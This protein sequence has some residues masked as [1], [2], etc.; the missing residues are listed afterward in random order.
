MAETADTDLRDQPTLARRIAAVLI[1]TYALVLL[2]FALPEIPLDGS[3]A[4]VIVR[5]ADSA[6][7]GQLPFLCIA[8]L[9]LLNSRPGPSMRRRAIEAVTIIVVMLGVIGG[10][11]LLNEFVIKPTFHVPRPNIVALAEDGALG[12]AVPD[13]PAFYELGDKQDR[14]DY[15]S[16]RLA[17]L[18][19][20]ALAPAVREHW[21]D[22]TGYSFPS[23][24]STASMTFASLM[25]ALG[26]CWL[27]G[28]RQGVT[29]ALPI[30]ALCVVYSRPLLQVHTATDVSVG[31]LVGICLGLLSFLLI[32]WIVEKLAP[33]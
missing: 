10:N 15:L 29:S 13:G 31:A 25:V 32:R 6:T 20:P 8:A 24:H 22:E 23:G 3:L 7:W 26:M 17:E 5:V 21:L 27:G 30:W 16:P 12:P 9:M 1:P 2:S 28:W 14:R 11:A 19:Q 18:E 4:E 33:Q